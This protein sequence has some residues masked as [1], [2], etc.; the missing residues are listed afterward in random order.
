MK[1]ELH[2][3]IDALTAALA[4][5]GIDVQRS[6]VIE[7]V[8][9]ARGHRNAHEM[10]AATKKSAA[11]KTATEPANE[12]SKDPEEADLRF[13]LMCRDT[14]IA[15]LR[16]DLHHTRLFSHFDWQSWGKVIRTLKVSAHHRKAPITDE[17]LNMLRAAEANN[18]CKSSAADRDQARYD[19][20]RLAEKLM[21]PLLVRLDMAEEMLGKGDI[22]NLPALTAIKGLLEVRASRDGNTHEECFIPNEHCDLDYDNQGVMLAARA[23]DILGLESISMRVVEDDENELA[24]ELRADMDSCHVEEAAVQL[25]VKSAIEALE[26]GEGSV[27]LYRTLMDMAARA[28]IDPHKNARRLPKDPG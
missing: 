19:V 21:A 8:A 23:F 28:G 9:K 22:F 10:M 17:N 12:D 25:S 20:Q 16:E 27:L 18:T 11:T 24:D 14:E 2:R 6:D 7:S 13:Q 4:D 26:R 1:T 5:R 3:E 15:Q